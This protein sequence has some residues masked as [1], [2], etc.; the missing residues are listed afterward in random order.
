MWGDRELLYDILLSMIM[1][2]VDIAI[3]VHAGD[4]SNLQVS[5]RFTSF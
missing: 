3:I 5:Y 2:P 4:L 1:S